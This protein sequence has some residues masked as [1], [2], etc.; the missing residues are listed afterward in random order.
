MSNEKTELRTLVRA[1]RNALSVHERAEKSARLCKEIAARYPLTGTVMSYLAFGSEVDLSAVHDAVLAAGGRLL[2]PRVEK[3][4]IVAVELVPEEEAVVS[5]FGITEPTGPEIDPGVIDVVLV[6]GLAFD[7]RGGRLGYG[8]GYYDQ[9]LTRVSSATPRV[10]TCFSAQ[11]V[12]RVPTE[13]HDE[14]V[15]VVITE[16]GVEGGRP[17]CD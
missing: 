14:L 2:V 8:A 1:R 7:R 9:F 4:R 17:T 13:P 16:R 11:L 12:D 3:P 15:D 5:G 6:P 10:G